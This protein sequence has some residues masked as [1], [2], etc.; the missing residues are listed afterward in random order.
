MAFLHAPIGEDVSRMISSDWGAGPR[1][2]ILGFSGANVSPIR[3]GKHTVVIVLEYIDSSASRPM[4]QSN[5]P[6]VDLQ[7]F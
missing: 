6:I 7:G 4:S 5:I 2:P 1:D 3:I